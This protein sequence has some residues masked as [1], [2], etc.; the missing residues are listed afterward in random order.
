MIEEEYTM[1][2]NLLHFALG[3]LL[4]IITLAWFVFIWFVIKYTWPVLLVLAFIFFAVEMF[5][6][7]TKK[8][9]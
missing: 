2:D 3:M 1:I 9:S 5:R 6:K 8:G 4:G 7:I